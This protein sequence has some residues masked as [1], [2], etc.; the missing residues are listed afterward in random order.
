[1]SESTPSEPTPAAAP[2][3]PLTVAVTGAS[4]LIGTA[5]VRRLEGDGHTV[6]RLVRRAPRG[7]GEVRWDPDAG[8]IDA[9]GLEGV[10]GVVHLAGEN[11][12]ARW[13]PER[14]RRIQA[15]RAG[16]TR[17]LVR[18]LSGLQRK[19]RVLVSASAVGLYGDRGDERLD[20]MSAPGGGFLAGVVR[21]WEEAARG[22]QAA[23]VRLVMLR[24][25]V[26][27]SARGGALQKLL[28]PFRLGAG[29]VVGSG[30]QWM[31]WLSLDDAV[32]LVMKALVDERLQG[33][34]NAAA[35][36]VTNSEFT[37]TLARV[38]GRPALVPVPAFALRLLFGEMADETILAS[39]RVQPR[40]LTQLGYSFHHGELEDAL[41][42]ALKDRG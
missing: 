42:A 1:M 4:G 40:V 23:G 30:R 12:G 11:V 10:D 33:P 25:G 29:G 6:L 14:K 35:G 27:L 18:A 21:D 38:L 28:T 32:D 20:E 5:V 34:V 41:R 7:P 16:A 22:V 15:S 2:P 8:T 19:P 9:G 26:V 39:Q 37:R 13:T 24:F 17:V 36:A 31:S 3:A